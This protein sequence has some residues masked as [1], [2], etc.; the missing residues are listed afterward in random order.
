LFRIWENPKLRKP[1]SR[2]FLVAQQVKYLVLS[3]LC[4]GGWIPGPRIS[5]CHRPGEKKKRKI[6]SKNVTVSFHFIVLLL[7]SSSPF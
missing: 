7:S 1:N 5:A 4:G 6:D 3:L 2:S